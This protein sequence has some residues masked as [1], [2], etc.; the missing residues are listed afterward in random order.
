MQPLEHSGDI[1]IL[2]S[3]VLPCLLVDVSEI[4]TISRPHSHLVRRSHRH[5]EAAL[6]FGRRLARLAK[7]LSDVRWDR[8][9]RP[10]CLIA[11]GTLFDLRKLQACSMDVQRNPVR[12]LEDLKVLKGHR[13][14]RLSHSI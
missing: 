5:H 3:P 11:K 6:E 4:E 14:H 12:S 9:A 10:A 7:S 2:A 8:L 1:I 13:R